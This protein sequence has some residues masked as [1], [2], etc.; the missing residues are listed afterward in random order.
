MRPTSGQVG[1]LKKPWVA[2]LPAAATGDGAPRS[3]A[4][5]LDD[6]LV[7]LRRRLSTVPD[8]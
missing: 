6:A 3:V 5:L 8:Q 2:V 7:R 4:E 1:S